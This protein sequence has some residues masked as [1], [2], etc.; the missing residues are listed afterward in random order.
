MFSNYY[1]VLYTS[2][3]PWEH[4]I[5]KFFSWISIPRLTTEDQACLDDLSQVSEI[6]ATID[7]LKANKSPAIAGLT[8]NSIQINLEIR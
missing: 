6:K 8:E 1:K 4:D 2:S 7:S 3:N 5:E